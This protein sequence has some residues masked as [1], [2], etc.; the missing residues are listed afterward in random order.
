MTFHK[1]FISINFSEA[2]ETY[3]LWAKHQQFAAAKLIKSQPDIRIGA[4]ILDAG[5]GTGLLTQMACDHY[6]NARFLGIDISEQMINHCQAKFGH[7][8][9]MQFL[10]HDLE[11]LNEINLPYHFDLILSS[12]TLQWITNVDHVLQTLINSLRP[13][14]YIGI[15]IPVKGSLFELYD[16]YYSAFNTQMAGLSYKDPDYY[17]SI[18]ERLHTSIYTVQVENICNLFNGIDILRYFKYTGTTFRHNPDYRPK[19]IKEI[20]TLLAYYKRNHGQN[21]KQLPLTFKVLFL[22]AQKLN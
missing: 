20:N 21:N 5:C 17:I 8:K 18:L 19:T 2:A 6:N 7:K 10:V 4:N 22:I 16:S 1:D 9:N 3:N 14:G 11:K 15:A 13:G 12:F